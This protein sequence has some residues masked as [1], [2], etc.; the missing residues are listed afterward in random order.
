MNVSLNE[1]L[2]CGVYLTLVFRSDILFLRL[3]LF[4]TL[5]RLRLL[6]SSNLIE[7]ALYIR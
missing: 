2:S 7:L 1:I 6:C 5:A 4:L 3:R